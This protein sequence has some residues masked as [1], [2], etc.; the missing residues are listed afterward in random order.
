M[1]PAGPR[2]TTVSCL[3]PSEG[4]RTDRLAPHPFPPWR[5]NLDAALDPRN[6]GVLVVQLQPGQ[7]GGSARSRGRALGDELEKRDGECVIM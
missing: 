1:R 2:I 3:L 7:G 4:T 5:Y 6:S